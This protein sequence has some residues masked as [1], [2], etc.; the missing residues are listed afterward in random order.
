[1][2]PNFNKLV[3]FTT[4][5]Y[6]ECLK[7]NNRIIFFVVNNIIL[8]FDEFLK[9]DFAFLHCH[10]LALADSDFWIHLR[11]SGRLDRILC[12]H[13]DRVRDDADGQ[14]RVPVDGDADLKYYK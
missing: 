9:L 3:T 14:E 1:M 8:K 13:D 11:K 10:I 12:V 5:L 4:E 2:L 6:K 7:L